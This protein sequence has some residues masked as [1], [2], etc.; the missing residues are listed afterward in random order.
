MGFRWEESEHKKAVQEGKRILKQIAWHW[1]PQKWDPRFGGPSLSPVK[2]FSS[3]AGKKA[4]PAIDVPSSEGFFQGSNLVDSV[5]RVSNRVNGTGIGVDATGGICFDDLLPSLD[6]LRAQLE[7]ALS[8]APT[9]FSST[10]LRKISEMGDIYTTV[11]VMCDP[12]QSS[13]QTIS[14]SKLRDLARA[15]LGRRDET[16]PSSST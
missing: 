6:P 9:A 8:A 13:E 16:T 11:T 3:G 14:F 12:P 5:I 4:D 15:E 2:I 7:K 1:K 10:D